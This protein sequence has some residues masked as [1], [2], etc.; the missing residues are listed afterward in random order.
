MMTVNEAHIQ[1][2][3]TIALS[4]ISASVSIV[5][6]IDFLSLD[7]H[8]EPERLRLFYDKQK[9]YGFA[10]L[11]AA[12]AMDAVERLDKQRLGDRSV[13]IHLAEP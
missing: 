2:K 9:V 3:I 4:N 7:G 6:V 10:E 8:V 1:K 12:H 11:S 5:E 13:S